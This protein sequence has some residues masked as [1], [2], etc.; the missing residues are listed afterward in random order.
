MAGYKDI[1]G[2]EKLKEHLKNALKLGKVS[3]AYIFNG[4]KGMGKKM[5]AKTFAMALQCEKNGD[6]PC[7]E[8][9]SCRQAL[10]DNHPDIKFVT[11]E[12]PN[13]ISVDE[14]RQQLTNDIQIKPYSGKY[15]IYIIDEAQKM[16]P[17][18]Q[19]AILK[20]IE[21]P[22]E[23]GIIILLTS[24]SDMFLPTILSRCVIMKMKTLENKKIKEYLMKNM[25]L[26]DYYADVIATFAAGNLGKAIRLATSED[27]NELKDSVVHLLQYIGD[28]EAYEVVQSVKQAEKY[29]VDF[30]DFIDLMMVW[31]RDVLIYKVSLDIDELTFKEQ[32]K[33]IKEQA[34]KI[35][36]NGIEAIIDAM[37]KAKVRLKANVNFDLAIEMMFLTIRDGLN[38]RE[39]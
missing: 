6:E 7:L 31:Y 38:G 24:N 27:F 25:D 37:E 10:S 32:C 18:A 12:K 17:Q 35:S 8:C 30:E 14:V 13:V 26:P 23:Y 2:N 21:E 9:K 16:N 5:I 19:N 20:T 36:F 29:K 11:H 39:P 33:Y 3:H 1:I 4:A 34:E 22:P 15:K 28:M